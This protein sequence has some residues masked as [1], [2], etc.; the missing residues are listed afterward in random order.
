M[1]APPTGLSYHDLEVSLLIFSRQ[2]ADTERFWCFQP[3]PANRPDQ[4][5][6]SW[7]LCPWPSQLQGSLLQPLA[8]SPPRSWSLQV[9]S[10]NQL[11]FQHQSS[12]LL[13]KCSTQF[14]HCTHPSLPSL[15]FLLP[16]GLPYS[17]APLTDVQLPQPATSKTPPLTSVNGSP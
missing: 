5:I 4:S 7:G 14:K 16:W 1:R 9:H 17:P 15:L 8:A 13:Q 2:L 12:F 11:I 10:H 3:K 6:C